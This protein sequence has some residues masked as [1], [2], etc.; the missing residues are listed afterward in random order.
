MNFF[1]EPY[2][3]ELLY[4]VVAR[5]HHLSANMIVDKTMLEIYGVKC[6]LSFDLPRYTQCLINRIPGKNSY[7]E[8]TFIRCHTLLPYYFPF[9]PEL[10]KQI[11]LEEMA[12]SKNNIIHTFLGDLTKNLQNFTNLRFCSECIFEDGKNFGEPFWHRVHQAPGNFYCLKHDKILSFG[13]EN[14]GFLFTPKNNKLLVLKQFCPVCNSDLT[15]QNQGW[16]NLLSKYRTDL[17]GIGTDI[18]CLLDEQH[19]WS[20]WSFTNWHKLYYNKLLKTSFCSEQTR[21]RHDKLIFFIERF[22]SKSFL[23]LLRCNLDLSNWLK[24]CIKCDHAIH[25]LKHIVLTRFLFGSLKELI[26]QMPCVNESEFIIYPLK[27]ASNGSSVTSGKS[28]KPKINWALRDSELY[29]LV[30]EADHKIRSIEG[31]PIRVTLNKISEEIGYRRLNANLEKL[32]KTSTLLKDVTENREEYQIRL[33]KWHYQVN[34]RFKPKVLRKLSSRIQY[35][36][37]I[38]TRILE[39]ID[40]LEDAA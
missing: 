16:S 1:P 38:L 9:L 28:I 6:T 23:K 7:D 26:N 2:P 34:A 30:R 40:H 19:L 17:I 22:Y 25:P 5:Y 21:I 33:L 10:N 31:K 11:V 37:K 20:R 39:E 24:A 13:C 15:F 18:C 29:I 36:E 35:N 14:C 3:D 32:P 12:T 4:S 8:Q 27:K